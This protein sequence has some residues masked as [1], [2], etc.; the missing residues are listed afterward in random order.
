MT[1]PKYNKKTIPLD[2]DGGEGGWKV[3]VGWIWMWAGKTVSQD[4]K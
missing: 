3:G 4:V 1:E 2:G